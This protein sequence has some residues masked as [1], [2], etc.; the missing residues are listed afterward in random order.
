MAK[1]MP[2]NGLLVSKYKPMKKALYQF[3]MIVIF[4]PLYLGC[5]NASFDCVRNTGAQTIMTLDLPDFSAINAYDGINLFIKEGAQQ[6]VLLEA[7]ENLLE[8]IEIAVDATG[9]LTVSNNNTCNWVRSYKDINLYITTDTL[10][11]IN[12]YGYGTIRSEGI[13][14]FPTV[15]INAKDGVGDIHV[16]VESERLYLVS[17][18]IANFYLSGRTEAFVIGNYYSDGRFSSRDLIARHVSVNQL[19]SNTIEVNAT[20]SI[21]GSIDGT[22]DVVYYGSPGTVEVKL[23]GKG[24]LIKK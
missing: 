19:G 2:W 13:W 18:S 12:Q 23:N 10:V 1:P 17:N 14:T 8:N 16:A 9:Y 3:C 22:G 5:E 15:T 20:E 4:A 11:H 24:Q 6:E 7:G 21:K